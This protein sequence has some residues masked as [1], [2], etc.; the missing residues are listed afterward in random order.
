MDDVHTST[1]TTGAGTPAGPSP[2]NTPPKHQSPIDQTRDAAKKVLA[3][4][5]GRTK[6]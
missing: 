5:T 3:M 1:A 6:S 4:I 2:T